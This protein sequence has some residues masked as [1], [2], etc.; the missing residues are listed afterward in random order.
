ML[1]LI[2]TIVLIVTLSFDLWLELTGRPTISETYQRLFPTW[3]DLTA[4]VILVPG[5]CVI[6]MHRVLVVLYC[7]IF[8]HL[9]W[10]NMERYKG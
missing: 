6:P 1:D 5:L 10:P 4:L 2:A 7:I 9:F 8:G 3:Y